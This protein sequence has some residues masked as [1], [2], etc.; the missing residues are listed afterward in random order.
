MQSK[1]TL[2]NSNQ[3]WNSKR[4]YKIN[5][6]VNYL[7]SIYQ[8]STGINTD[9]ILGTDWV[10]VKK[11]DII[12]L[13][14]HQDFYADASQQFTV[15]EGILIENVFINFV[16]AAGAD[17]NQLGQIITVTSSITGDFVTLTGRN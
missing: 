10:I 12:P 6:V 16:S 8:N 5:S 1:V 3:S 14:F 15:P 2:I 9:P 13:V 7:G 17:W 11:L 4:R